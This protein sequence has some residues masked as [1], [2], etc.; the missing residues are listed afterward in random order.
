MSGCCMSTYMCEVWRPPPLPN[1]TGVDLKTIYANDEAYNKYTKLCPGYGYTH[2]PDISNSTVASAGLGAGYI[3]LIFF[4]VL[5]PIII[6]GVVLYKCY[7]NQHSSTTLPFNAYKDIN[8][9]DN[10][11]CKGISWQDTNATTRPSPIETSLTNSN[12]DG[13]DTQAQ[14]PHT[15][16]ETTAVYSKVDRN[17]GKGQ[18]ENAAT[19]ESNQSRESHGRKMSKRASENGREKVRDETSSM[20][21]K[22]CDKVERT[23]T[24]VES[25]EPE[26]IDEIQN[27]ADQNS[28]NDVS[29]TLSDLIAYHV[30]N[31]NNKSVNTP[32]SLNIY[33]LRHFEG[34]N[35]N[36][37]PS[38]GSQSVKH[39]NSESQIT[40]PKKRKKMGMFRK[41]APVP[42]Q[43]DANM[44]S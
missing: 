41:S 7:N 15:E 2:G 21:R 5:L 1:N 19:G 44:P 43:N 25:L 6:I 32:P 31:S 24:P 26:E 8:Y 28:A 34:R 9:L 11:A 38:L 33:D 20:K 12:S 13:A 30:L 36:R 3:V 35:A 10:K 37:L 23:L 17:V 27:K 18:K 14:S 4:A 29:R 42:S 22:N 16:N 39:R 40:S